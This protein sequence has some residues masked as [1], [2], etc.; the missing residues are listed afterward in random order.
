MSPTRTPRPRLPIPTRAIPTRP[1]DDRT[2]RR[3]IHLIVL[4]RRLAWHSERDPRL[5]LILI[6]T[7]RLPDIR[8]A[9]LRRAAAVAAVVQCVAPALVIFD[10]VGEA[11]VSLVPLRVL[12]VE[13]LLAVPPVPERFVGGDFA[14]VEPGVRALGGGVEDDVDFFQ[15]AVA[16]FRVQEVD[17][18]E[19]GE[20]ARCGGQRDDWSIWKGG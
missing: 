18:G 2:R 5:L 15:A 20:V 10:L 6:T 7:Q 16:G 17:D 1:T 13:G 19:G 9:D 11:H 4:L 12:V 3:G 8:T 14:H